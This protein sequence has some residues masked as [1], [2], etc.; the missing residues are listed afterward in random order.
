[1]VGG[2]HALG[3][4]SNVPPL[5][6]QRVSTLSRTYFDPYTEV[7]QLHTLGGLKLKGAVFSRPKPLQLLA[8]LVLEGRQERRHLS[9]LF[10]PGTNRALKNLSNVLTRLKEAASGIVEGDGVRIWT[11]LPCDAQGLLAA[12]EKRELESS[13]EAYVGPFLEGLSPKGLSSELEEW[14]LQTREFIAARVREALQDLAER[15]ASQGRVQ[16]ALKRAERALVLAGAPPL[17]PQ[18]LVRLHTL[19]LAGGSLRAEEVRQEALDFDVALVASQAEAEEQLRSLHQQEQQSGLGNLPD[20]NTSFVGRQLELSEV[21]ELLGHDECRLLS[22]VGV[23]GV[24]K[25]RLALQVAHKQLEEGGFADR[26]VFVPLEAVTDA[27]SITAVAAAAL[28][29]ELS[30]EEDASSVVIRFLAEKR[31]LLVLDNFERLLEGTPF[32]RELIDNCP[33]LKLLI[34]TRERLNLEAEWVFEVEGLAYPDEARS[35]ERAGYFDAVQLFLMRAKRAQPRFSLTPETLPAVTRICRLVDGMPLAL[36]LAASW[37]RALPLG[38]VVKE[39]EAGTDRLEAPARDVSERHRSVQAVFDHSWALLSRREKEVLR[40]LS[41]F[42]GGFT[43]KAA[44]EIADVTLPGLASLVDKSFLRMSPEGRYDRHPLLAQYTREK[45]AELPEER[46]ETEQRHGAYYLRF[47]RELE[48]DLGTLARK[49]AF[50][51]FLEELAN[52]RAAWDWATLNLEIEEIEETTPAMYDFFK[53]RFNG[54]LEHFGT[55]FEFFGGI[56]ERLD[57]DDPNHAGA[58]GMVLIH[59]VKGPHVMHRNPDYLRV[60]SLATRGIELLS[61]RSEPRALARGL[62]AIGASFFHTGETTRGKEW[63]ERALAMARKH[64]TSTDIADALYTV[65]FAQAAETGGSFAPHG[66]FVEEGLEEMR[67]LKYLPGVAQF[68]IFS[69]YTLRDEQRFAEAIVLFLKANRLAAELGHHEFVI[70]SLHSLASESI[71]LGELDQASAYAQ[72]ASKR[73]EEAGMLFFVPSNLAV[74]GRV[75]TA[76]GD[77]EGAREL[78]L[79]SLKVAWARKHRAAANM[80]LLFLAELWAAEGSPGEAVALLA[81]REERYQPDRVLAEL[82]ASMTPE[83]FAA[84]LERGRGRTLEDVMRE[85]AESFPGSEAVE[86]SG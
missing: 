23:G 72:E 31:L 55:T 76:Q 15:E 71:E 19:L 84:A 61:S 86:G 21:A 66:R 2:K 42:R 33:Q 52:I 36:E 50:R 27:A 5:C 83:E 25:T 17:E 10:W 62:H 30:G 4:I 82:E 16:Q 64:G 26:V 43:R 70:I 80:A 24:G 28:R 59:Q 49:E 11:T 38:E 22:L 44:S 85:L 13:I 48:P 54:G 12:L 8:Y 34:T 79:R 6:F 46:K 57:E 35:V 51:V 53:L 9:E 7:M 56:A 63:F 78:L 40:R 20:R 58:L 1:M 73:V 29:L 65:G 75:A 45:L 14:V 67:A 77:F 47:V 39:M 32:I 41:V 74:L 69:G 37:L 68:L 81:Y 60:R 3:G 18:D